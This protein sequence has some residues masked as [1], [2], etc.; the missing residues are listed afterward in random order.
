MSNHSD[1]KRLSFFTG[2]FTTA[3][4]WNDGQSYHLEKRKLHNRGL[5]TPGVIRGEGDELRVVAGEGL[6]VQVL[7]GAALDGEGHELYLGQPRIIALDLASYTLPQL[8]FV[9]MRYHEEETDRAENVEAPQYSGFTRVTE[10]PR[11]EVTTSQPDNR[12]LL[13]LARIHLQPGVTQVGDAADPDI[14][15]GNDIDR[16]FAVWA[17]AVAVAEA[18][19][20]P[21][22]SQRL[23]QLMGR[24]RGDFAALSARFPVPSETDVR[25]GAI[26]VEMLARAG[27]LR[28]D[29]VPAVLASLAS[30]EQD[31]A[32]EI[33]LAYAF[34][35]TTSE[36]QAYQMAVSNLAA[37]L[38][39]GEAVDAL[40]NRQDEVARAARELAEVVLQPPVAE[41]GPDATVPASGDEA[42]LAL[43]ASGSRAFGGRRIVR[44]RW[45]L[46]ESELRPPIADAGAD[47]T[48]SIPGD[49]AEVTLDA[50]GS[51]AL[52][53]RTIVRYRWEQAG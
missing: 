23:V 13:E 48:V 46:V 15:A 12:S 41:A 20:S 39:D 27:C 28:L 31:V 45:T 42:S 52:D 53:G 4:D 36:F 40:F 19:M 2:F 22:D 6:Q 34:L 11:L 47:R 9:A 5:H 18:R 30:V 35:V 37:A 33:A 21:E 3:K 49:E 44:Y 51:R 17:G 16:R 14:P 43:D 24:T 32:Q 25:Q 7:P 50:R 26:T 29:Q 1:F 8:V 38:R 10:S